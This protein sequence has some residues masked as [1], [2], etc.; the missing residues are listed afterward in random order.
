[1]MEM[2]WCKSNFGAG[3]F[4]LWQRHSNGRAASQ[5]QSGFW[6]REICFSRSSQRAAE[7]HKLLDVIANVIQEDSVHATAVHAAVI[8]ILAIAATCSKH[9]GISG[10]PF[11]S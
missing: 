9:G 4:K 6:N 8:S 7:C 11:Q 2:M 5:F 10:M 3:C 1:M